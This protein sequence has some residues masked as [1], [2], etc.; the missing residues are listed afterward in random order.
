MPVNVLGSREGF[1]RVVV[2]ELLAARPAG[3]GAVHPGVEDGDGCRRAA[4]Q[5]GRTREPVDPHGAD[6]CVAGRPEAE[7]GD[8]TAGPAAG[9]TA[10]GRLSQAARWLS[11][12]NSE[13]RSGNE[14][15]RDLTNVHGVCR[16]RTL[17]SSLP[18]PASVSSRPVGFSSP[19]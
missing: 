12:L 3:M 13:A 8:G 18:R 5:P 11:G 7:G 15:A 6:A 14:A 19:M 16:K 10:P 17:P 2:P 4:A 1:R 9:G